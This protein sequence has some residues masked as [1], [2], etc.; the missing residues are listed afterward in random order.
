M[1]YESEHIFRKSLGLETR[2][3]DMGF[4][5]SYITSW[6]VYNHQEISFN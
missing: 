3:A 6:M 2:Y 1:E 5:I 4:E